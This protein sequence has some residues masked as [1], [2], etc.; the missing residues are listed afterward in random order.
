MR[1]VDAYNL[2]V[3]DG[4]SDNHR[5]FAEVYKAFNYTD[6]DSLADYVDFIVHE[7]L[8][9]MQGF[10]AKLTTKTSFSK[11]K[12]AII[13]LL[14]KSQVQE[15]L[16]AEVADAAYTVIWNTFKKEHETLLKEREGRKNGNR[17]RTVVEHMDRRS[18]GSVGTAEAE[19][20]GESV[21]TTANAKIHTQPHMVV[22]DV[23]VDILSDV[24]SEE[25]EIEQPVPCGRRGLPTPPL[26]PI[27]DAVKVSIWEP[28]RDTSD[29]ERIVILKRALHHLASTLPPGVSDAFRALVDAV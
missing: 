19:E 4:I 15:D 21:R 12:T 13:K 3:D 27:P 9:W 29:M 8:H 10:P 1:L 2:L 26:D 7:P 22:E 11:P 20:D 18:M 23:S 14:K 5:Y 28:R 16:G 24:G 17:F 25:E 6:E